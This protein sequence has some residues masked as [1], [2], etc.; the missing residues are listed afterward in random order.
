[1]TDTP[2]LTLVV[3][4]SEP[5]PVSAGLLSAVETELEEGGLELLIVSSRRPHV[6]DDA[7][8][9]VRWVQAP[10][11]ATVPQRRGIGL[12]EARAPLVALSESF[13]VPGTGWASAVLTAHGER[14]VA[15]VGGPVMRGD[16]TPMDWALT[17]MEYGRFLSAGRKG[18]VLD[19]PGVNVVYRVGALREVFGDLPREVMEIDIHAR[20]RETGRV[21]WWEP[22]A[23]MLDKSRMALGAT[24]RSQFLHG[25]FFGSRRVSDRSWGI[26]LLRLMASPLVPAVLLR[27]IWRG[28]RA[29]GARGNFLRALPGLVA[30]TLAWSA[31]EAVGSVRR[32]TGEADHWT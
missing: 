1:M 30:L 20:L 32:G 16:G 29:A 12:A 10:P 2:T 14:K 24:L 15:A 26:R 19:L 4:E 13:C 6:M 17:L 11:G 21:L 18:P 23:V 25:R 5:G 3:A 28:A 9:G 31:G 27:R 8:I 22:D 7:P